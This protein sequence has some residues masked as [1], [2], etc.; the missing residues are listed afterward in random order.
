M[1][2]VITQFGCQS[3]TSTHINRIISLGLDQGPYFRLPRHVPHILK[4]PKSALIHTTFI[5]SLK[6]L[7]SKMSASD[8]FGAIFL[9]HTDRQIRTKNY[10]SCFFW[11]KRYT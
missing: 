2:K 8:P 4:C 7:K 6:S 9:S 5:P 10:P 11:R 3:H 1:E